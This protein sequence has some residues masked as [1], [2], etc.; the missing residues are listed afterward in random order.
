MREYGLQTQVVG[1]PAPPASGASPVVGVAAIDAGRWAALQADGSLTVWARSSG[2]VVAR[3]LL[4]EQSPA[5][6]GMQ[7]RWLA[8]SYVEEHEALLA[9][10]TDGT[11]L[12]L[13]PPTPSSSAALEGEVVGHVG[14]GLLA[15]AWAPD[16]SVLL[17]VSA[18]SVLLLLTPSWDVLVETPAAAPLTADAGAA[19]AWRGD[20]RFFAVL[21]TEA[22]GAAGAAAAAAAAAGSSRRVLRIY[23]QD[24]AC[25]GTGRNEDGSPVTGLHA[26]VA[27]SPDGA[28]V[29]VG[30]DVAARSRVQVA[31]FETNGL[32]HRELVL[33]GATPGRHTLAWCAWNAD[34]DVL[35]THVVGA[36]DADGSGCLQWWHRDNYHWYAKRTLHVDARA[37]VDGGGC[38]WHPERP[39]VFA[40]VQRDTVAGTANYLELAFGW[41]YAVECGG[42]SSRAATVA[43]CDEAARL[44]ITPTAICCVP[45]PMAYVT[46]ALAPAALHAPNEVTFGSRPH[47][48][49]GSGDDGGDDDAHPV[50]RPL[51][52]TAA[53]TL[54]Y[55]PLQY[56]L[57]QDANPPPPPPPSSAAAAA[58]AA[59]APPDAPVGVTLGLHTDVGS[60]RMAGGDEVAWYAHLR[61]APVCTA[62]GA[63]PTHLLPRHALRHLTFLHRPSPSTMVLAAVTAGLVDAATGAFVPGD[64]L[65]LLAVA[66]PAATP[67]ATAALV[68]ASLTVWAPPATAGGAAILRLLPGLPGSGA[69]VVHTSDCGVHTQAYDGSTGAPVDSPTLLTHLLEPAS[70]LAVLPPHAPGAHPA[71]V[72]LSART[73]RL[74]LNTTLLSP[75]AASF[76]VSPRH[77]WLLF[78]TVGPTPT[79]GAVHVSQLAAAAGGAT[80]ALAAAAVHGDDGRDA[81]AAPRA[82]E[83]GARLVGVVDATDAVLLQMPRGNLETIT[84]RVLTLSS[85]RA[86]LSAQP[87]PR[88]HEALEACR[89]HRVDMNLLVDYSPAAFRHQ[90]WL[91]SA[92]P[93]VAAAAAAGAVGPGPR[94]KAT[95]GGGSDRWDLLLSALDPNDVTTTRYPVPPYAAPARRATDAAAAAAPGAT[96]ALP[97]PIAAADPHLAA[98]LAAHDDKVN[99]AAAAVRLALLRNMLSPDGA[100]LDWRHPLV[101]SVITSYARQVPPD[102]EAMLRVVQRV[103]AAE[104]GGGGGGGSVTGDAA[105]SHAVVVADSDVELLYTT[106]L[107]MYDL[108]LAHTIAQRGQSDPREYLPFLSSLV[109]LGKAREGDAPPPTS[110]AP[111]TAPLLASL[112]DGVLRQRWAIDVHLARWHKA[113]AALAH[114]A[115]RHLPPPAATPA[116]ASDGGRAARMAALRAMAG[117][118]PAAPAAAA[119]VPSVA[120]AAPSAAAVRYVELP[121]P[122]ECVT[123][124][125]S[126]PADVVNRLVDRDATLAASVH[127][128]ASAPADAL[129]AAGLAHPVQVLLAVAVRHGAGAAVAEVLPADAGAY[130]RRLLVVEAAWAALR[131]ASKVVGGAAGRDLTAHDDDDDGGGGGGGSGARGYELLLARVAPREVDA[132]TIGSAP[133]PA[134]CTAVAAFLHVASPPAVDEAAA[135]CFAKA[136]GGGDALTD[137]LVLPTPPTT[138]VLPALGGNG[139]GGGGGVTVM[140]MALS[141]A[142]HPRCMLRNRVGGGEA[143][144]LPTTAALVADVAHALTA[145]VGVASAPTGAALRTAAHLLTAVGSLDDAA[146]V[147][148]KA[149]EWAAGAAALSAAGAPALVAAVL[150]PSLEAAV[151][152]FCD[153]AAS[154]IAALPEAA[155]A[156]AACRELRQ[157]MTLAE[158]VGTAELAR[159]RTG[160]ARLL[161]PDAYAGGDDDGADG[162]GGGGGAAGGG[163]D[164]WDDG[165]SAWSDASSVVSGAEWEAGSAASGSGASAGTGRSTASSRTAGRFSHMPA[166][167]LPTTF[168]NLRSSLRMS[169]EAIT[170][171]QAVAADAAAAQRAANRMDAR[172]GGGMDNE[173]AAAK[174]DRARRRQ[175][176]K[177]HRVRPGSAAEEKEAE[178]ALRGLLPLPTSAFLADAASLAAAATHCLLPAAAHAVL[179]AAESVVAAAAALPPLPPRRDVPSALL[180]AL[181][182]PTAAA[183]ADLPPS[184][185]AGVRALVDSVSTILHL[186]ASAADDD[187]DPVRWLA[188]IRGADEA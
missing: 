184:V 6:S 171:S 95:T 157:R 48:G 38:G 23:S 172:R 43:V 15:A 111:A 56:D 64:R 99:C 158:L 62:P 61:G 3:G 63:A 86:A 39:H 32:R 181:L 76:T 152:A 49:S 129:V 65:L 161:H 25:S 167:S 128:G 91:A 41:R 87:V 148:C 139:G 29:A 54:V 155:A 133:M 88:L 52:L 70:A 140:D 120:A 118:A 127:A 72:A 130:L 92:V 60:A 20:G 185:L 169:A 178:A 47:G 96:S 9:V 46:L 138:L 80:D 109:K 81:G 73:S 179:R 16:Q 8:L 154:R 5:A 31:F 21:G 35:A 145:P 112:S 132:A 114:L 40:A 27:W 1:P 110:P 42:C 105:L 162:G 82:L 75:A 19:V 17:L 137:R 124:A 101:L 67:A 14:D 131:K 55:V 153:D 136:A 44:A 68:V 125:R 147:Y 182:P 142:A 7:H 66:T 85:I 78:V 113:A 119:A 4:P 108:P 174:A 13:P 183:G 106:A 69:V 34:A 79:L 18:A 177:A 94:R 53:D 102:L 149:R 97:P 103:A 58:T 151:A 89:A 166:S 150:T 141:L 37:V 156:L 115:A 176:S 84:P 104:V 135:V 159:V 163:G 121:P 144:L 170:P 12:L 11:L 186:A 173:R 90:A 10:H 98:A 126:L 175:A 93:A 33:P 22:V 187:T 2:G 24:G 71:I 123:S 188:S 59:A 74:Y 116:P 50:T 180:A 77:G 143:P 164:D 83:R 160:A 51:V 57:P 28:L 134:V 26:V 100:A 168:T 36:A 30:Q 107:G 122:E 146:E 165:A 45:P 117:S